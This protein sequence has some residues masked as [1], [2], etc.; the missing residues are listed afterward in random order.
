[1]AEQQII[2]Q[3]RLKITAPHTLMEHLVLPALSNTFN[4]H[5]QVKLE[6]ICHDGQLDLVQDILCAAKHLAIDETD[7]DDLTCAI[8]KLPYV[9]NHWQDKHIHHVLS[10]ILDDKNSLDLHFTSQNKANTLPTCINMIEQGF[11]LGIVPDFIF[12]KHQA[13]LQK[14]LPNFQ[15]SSA[16]VY[17]FPPLSNSNAIAVNMAIQAITQHLKG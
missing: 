13:S 8:Q 10:D 6:L 12:E 15:L 2:P 17:A 5:T 7:D 1:M 11:G 9:A 4:Q 16:N 14:I 3:G